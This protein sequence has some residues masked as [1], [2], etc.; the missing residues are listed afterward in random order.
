M[1]WL[2][3]FVVVVAVAGFLDLVGV[4]FEAT[5]FHHWFEKED[6][7]VKFEVIVGLLTAGS[8][9]EYEDVAM[10]FGLFVDFLTADSNYLK[11]T[12]SVD[13]VKYST[14]HL[15]HWNQNF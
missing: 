5:H 4:G 12:E 8:H 9:Y 2:V 7:T 15:H 1:S 11:W 14:S 13:L 3:V 10:K 6:F